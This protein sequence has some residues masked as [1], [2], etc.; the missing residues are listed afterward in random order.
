MGTPVSINLRYFAILRE[1]RGLSQENL[2]TTAKTPGELYAQLKDQ[3]GF[4]L[5]SDRVGVAINDHF[6]TM[7]R[8]L[9]DGDTIVFVPPVAGG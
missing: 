8:I 9:Q 5:S 1:Q 3:Y 6:D 4:T 7:D 2:S